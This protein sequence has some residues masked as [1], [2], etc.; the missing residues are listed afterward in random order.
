[1]V[2]DFLTDLLDQTED[3]K[4][5]EFLFHCE[6]GDEWKKGG[7]GGGEWGE[8]LNGRGSVLTPVGGRGG[9][10]NRLGSERGGPIVE[11]EE[12]IRRESIWMRERE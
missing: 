12:E 10:W 2:H 11:G 9:G 7:D 3:L 4:L 1:M 8:G 5:V 6:A